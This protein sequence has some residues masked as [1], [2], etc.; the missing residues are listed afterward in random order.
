MPN[1]KQL[2]RSPVSK[3]IDFPEYDDSGKPIAQVMIKV[4]SEGA[5]E[6]VQIAATK[7]TARK[8]I[9]DKIEPKSEMYKDLYESLYINICSRHVLF[10]MCFD[11][12]NPS[13]TFFDTPDDV[14]KMSQLQ[15]EYF[16]VEYQKL[17]DGHPFFS[18]M[19]D[20][21]F[22][23]KITEFA[24]SMEQGADFLEHRLLSGMQINFT[25]YLIRELWKS[26]QKADGQSLMLESLRSSP[27]KSLKSEDSNKPPPPSL[28]Q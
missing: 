13:M 15:I 27:S 20:A 14:K 17:R 23:A 12:E 2:L 24:D 26:R 9:D 5:H 16:N 22:E 7:E 3:I 25:L 4:L 6:E 8:L 19:T 1:F 11:P 28:P 18:M 10:K 21:D